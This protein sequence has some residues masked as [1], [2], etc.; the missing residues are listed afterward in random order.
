MRVCQF[1]HDGKWT[2]AAANRMPLHQ[3]DLHL[4]FYREDAGCQTS[5]PVR[6]TLGSSSRF[7][8]VLRGISAFSAVQDFI[9]E[10]AEKRRGLI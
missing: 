4:L 8:S 6:G 10:S 5:V 7:L 9:A 1:R 3:E 2:S